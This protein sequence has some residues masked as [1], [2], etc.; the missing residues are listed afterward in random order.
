MLVAKHAS[1][2]HDGRCPAHVILR[3]HAGLPSLR[4]HSVFV[5]IRSAFARTSTRRF[6]V[7]HF[8]VHGRSRP[9]P[10]RGRRPPRLSDAE[11][12]A[13]R[14]ASRRR[15]IGRSGGTVAL[16]TAAVTPGTSRRRARY[17][18]RSGTFCGT[19]G[20]TLPTRRGSIPAHGPLVHRLATA[21]PG[22]SIS[23]PRGVTVHVARARRMGEGTAG[24]KAASPSRSRIVLSVGS[25]IACHAGRESLLARAYSSRFA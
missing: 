13:S 10:R 21:N 14:Y 20:S 3:A 1:L 19:A 7:L 15:S 8:S 12:E 24:A 16:G 18:A 11:Y 25:V 22:T 9:S 17:A 2:V 23:R 5:A 6:R 4:R